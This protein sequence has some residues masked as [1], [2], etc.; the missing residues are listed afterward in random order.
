MDILDLS[1]HYNQEV[2]IVPEIIKSP[3][4]KLFNPEP[5]ELE[6]THFITFVNEMQNLGFIPSQYFLD[7]I[8][9]DFLDL[10]QCYKLLIPKLQHLV[11]D[12]VKHKPMY[13][14]FPEEVAEKSDFELYFNALVHYISFGEWSPEYK[15]EVREKGIELGVKFKIIGLNDAKAVSNKLNSLLESYDSLTAFDKEAIVFGIDNDLIDI[16]EKTEIPFAETRCLVLQQ[17]M[18]NNDVDSFSKSANNVTDVLRVVTYLSGGDISLSTNTKFK[19]FKRYERRFLTMVI[20]E[21]WDD[22]TAYR[23]KNKWIKLLHNIH[24][25][26]YSATLWNKVK[27]LRNDEKVQT[28]NGQVEQCLNEMNIKK[29]IYLLK[30][31]P[32][33]FAR[34]LDHILRI[35]DGP[36]YVISEFND[37]IE[38][39][40]TKILIQLY[41]HFKHR[42]TERKSVV[43][44]KGSTVKAVLIDQK[45]EISN[46]LKNIVLNC[47]ENAL[48]KRFND[49][50]LTSKK[51]YID[52]RLKNC[53]VPSGM[54]SVSDGLVTVPRGTQFD[55]GDDNILRF[56]VY[57]VGM[58]ID[59]SASFHDKDF[60]YLNH[61]SYTNLRE[62]QCYHSGD[63]INGLD[64]GT[65]FIDVNIKHA[66]E[67][68]RYIV[69]N[70]FVYNGPTFAEHEECFVGYMTRTNPG[71]HEVFDPKTVKQKLDVTNKSRYVCPL[72]FDLEERKVIYIDMEK[73]INSHI[74]GNNIESNR[75][76]VEDIL[77]ASV[78]PSKMSLYD[79]FDIHTKTNL[80]FKVRDKER[81]DLVFDLEE[82]N[83]TPYDWQEIQTE[84]MK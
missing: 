44:P 62:G 27:V 68:A 84:W 3:F 73:K 70:V 81:A 72:I 58:D 46:N 34:R 11:G 60:K 9:Q 49:S 33:E 65:E 56:F 36:N 38:Y 52:P 10:E 5:S 1:L 57:W 26:D 4:N 7:L 63:I 51:I 25:G 14:N 42:T 37:I 48:I 40:P 32:S 54:R 21:L 2:T 64:G 61:I 12:H 29:A 69:M 41:G 53:P 83:I 30:Q 66:K 67:K 59:L 31:R 47:I 82:G 76:G 77:Y 78:N 13:P 74:F 16:S 6:K 55:F 43:L 39:I 24:V 75:A 20:E 35:T 28:F 45:G 15:E 18:K 79:L 22:E 50:P 23:H 80:N 17:F 19:N 71:K 8:S